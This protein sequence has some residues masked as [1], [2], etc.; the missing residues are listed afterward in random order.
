MK[1]PIEDIKTWGEIIIDDDKTFDELIE[2]YLPFR[3]SELDTEGILDSDKPKGKYQR[4]CD[5][6]DSEVALRLDP[7]GPSLS[8][9]ETKLIGP[10]PEFRALKLLNNT[11]EALGESVSISKKS[12][13]IV[14]G[15]S[16]L[17][18]SIKV[19]NGYG[20]YGIEVE[21]YRGIEE[22]LIEE[23]PIKLCIHF[24]KT[25]ISMVL[26]TEVEMKKKLRIL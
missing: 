8:D 9:I 14:E 2:F 22:A 16:S 5:E 11:Y 20:N 13:F 6:S 19:H 21:A 26:C 3:L 23:T 24:F 17:C 25:L 18:Y 4:Y 1:Y 15:M 12:S 10:E 7:N